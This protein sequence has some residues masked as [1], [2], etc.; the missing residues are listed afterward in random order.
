MLDESIVHDYVRAMAGLVSPDSPRQLSIV[1]TAMHGVG[2][3][4]LRAVFDG[5]R[6]HRPDRG[7][8]A[9]RPDPDFSTVAFPNPEEPGAMDLAL[10][11][12]D[13][14]GA[15]LIIANDP[16]ADRCAVGRAVRRRRLADAAR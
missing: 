6:L 12:A 10:A 4:V 2:A 11:L 1:H 9:G 3:E 14:T 16:D 15:D 5:G 7:G 13:R 8:R